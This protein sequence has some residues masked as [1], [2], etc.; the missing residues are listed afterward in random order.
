MSFLRLFSAVLFYDP[1][2]MFRFPTPYSKKSTSISLIHCL[3]RFDIYYVSELGHFVGC[4]RISLLWFHL[5]ITMNLSLYNLP[6]LSHCEFHMVFRVSLWWYF[7]AY[8]FELVAFHS[9]M[10]VLYIY[11]SK[12]LLLLHRNSRNN[13]ELYKISVR[14]KFPRSLFN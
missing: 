4:Y 10:T 9:R 8:I 13:T 11:F 5:T 2:S 6:N 14:E 1:I 7:T 12:C 3:S